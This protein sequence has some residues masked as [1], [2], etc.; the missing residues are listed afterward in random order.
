MLFFLTFN[1]FFGQQLDN[2]FNL[3]PNSILD[4][5]Y[6]HYGN[7]Y[8]LS[9]LLVENSAS[10]LGIC[11]PDSIFNLYFEVGS[12]MEDSNNPIHLARRA[13]VCEVFEAISSFINTPLTSTGNKVNIWVRNINNVATTTNGFLG[14]ASS[15]YM[16][17]SNSTIGGIADN[18]IWKTIHTGYDSY[19]NSTLP[20]TLQGGSNNQSGILFHGQVTFNF[21]STNVPAINFNTDLTATTIPINEF[22]FYSNSKPI[23][24]N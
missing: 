8:K 13:V 20:L 3:T 21:N 2:N 12:G 15:F 1:S 22:D 24:Y 10:S 9:D 11:S 19:L 6:D 7:K 5:I 16:I 23:F 17:P 14:F 4:N 18:K